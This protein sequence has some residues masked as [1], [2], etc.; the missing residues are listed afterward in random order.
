V[1]HMHALQ[2][3]PLDGSAEATLDS[4]HAAVKY[5]YTHVTRRRPGRRHLGISHP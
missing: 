2:R 1:R 5:L 4:R 3:L